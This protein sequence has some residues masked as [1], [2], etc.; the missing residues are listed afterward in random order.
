MQI[1]KN[2]TTGGVGSIK[3]LAVDQDQVLGR[4]YLYFIYNDLH[5]SP[6]GLVEDLF[7]QE[8]AR[9]RGIGKSLLEA[10]V[11][12]AKMAGCYKI[13]GTSRHERSLVHEWYKKFGFIDYG[14]EFRLDI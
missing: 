14:L 6:Y 2:R 5:D 8:G 13:I 4:V 12:E 3:F 9:R 1:T 11:G 7:V 10:V